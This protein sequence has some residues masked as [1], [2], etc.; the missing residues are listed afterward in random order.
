M[1]KFAT[2]AL[3]AAIANAATLR[4][5]DPQQGLQFIQIADDAVVEEVET[6]KK[7]LNGQAQVDESKS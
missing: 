1:L 3:V 4:Q 6:D 5:A 7:A 2:I